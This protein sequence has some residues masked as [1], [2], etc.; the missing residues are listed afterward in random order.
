[1]KLSHKKLKQ[2]F[3]LYVGLKPA[4]KQRLH[5]IDNELKA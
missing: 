1:M 2:F 3:A 5:N 4:K